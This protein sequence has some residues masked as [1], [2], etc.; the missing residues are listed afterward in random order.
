MNKQDYENIKALIMR[1]T[2]KGE[3]AVGV[4]NLLIK[5]EQEIKTHHR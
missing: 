3:E 1:C 2:L 5:I 4:A